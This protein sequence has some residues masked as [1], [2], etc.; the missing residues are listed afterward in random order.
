M[1]IEGARSFSGLNGFCG[2]Y[3]LVSQHPR[4]HNQ[5]YIGFTINPRRRIR[6]HNGEIKQGARKTKRKRP[7]KMVCFVSG[8]SC[9]TAALQFEW[10]WQHPAKVADVQDYIPQHSFGSVKSIRFHMFVLGLLLRKSQWNVQPLNVNWTYAETMSVGGYIGKQFRVG[11][12]L[13][14]PLPATI[15]FSRVPLDMCSFLTVTRRRGKDGSGIVIYNQKDD[16]SDEDDGEWDLGV[17]DSDDSSEESH[18][19][20]DSLS[21]PDERII[22]MSKRK[23]TRKHSSIPPKSKCSSDHQ[24][25]IS[26]K[27]SKL[28]AKRRYSHSKASH[29]D[30]YCVDEFDCS[31]PATPCIVPLQA[32][33]S[34]SVE[35]QES[36]ERSSSEL[37]CSICLL[38]LT[39]TFSQ[40][41]HC[42]LLTHLHCIAR[43]YLMEQD[44][45]IKEKYSTSEQTSLTTSAYDSNPPIDLAYRYQSNKSYRSKCAH[46]LSFKHSSSSS[47]SSN[48]SI[49]SLHDS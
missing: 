27:K 29:D 5:C 43:Y 47:S 23:G 15:T 9:R 6:Q 21:D 41:P 24:T 11:D 28:S 45:E 13:Y 44:R 39:H 40:C 7:W 4:F 34:S 17:E 33:T 2:V 49:S 8:F 32:S 38:P 35:S 3:C 26:T 10:Q 36:A 12:V 1:E 18:Y 48:I 46:G 30:E 42:S 19:R 14:P 37:V 20:C 22:S 16:H 25:A 31:I